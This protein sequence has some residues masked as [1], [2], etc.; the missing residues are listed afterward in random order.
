MTEDDDLVGGLK[1][2]VT[3]MRRNNSD[4]SM[5]RRHNEYHRAI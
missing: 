3:V 2:K 4:H 5:L 1:G